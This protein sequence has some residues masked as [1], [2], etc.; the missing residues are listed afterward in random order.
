MNT[1]VVDY[2]RIGLVL[3]GAIAQIVMGGLPDILG[4]EHTISSRSYESQTFVVPAGYAFSIWGVIFLGCLV[5]AIFH[6]L[7][8][9]RTDPAFRQLG[10]LAAIAFWGNSIWEIYVPLMGLDFG[11]L[12]IILLILIA[13]ISAMFIL[14]E[15]NEKGIAFVPIMLMAGWI[16][17]ATF[18]NIS[19]TT[20]LT[21][22]NPFNLSLTSQ[23]IIIILTAG[24]LTTLFAWSFGSIA[25][26]FAVSWGLAAIY[27]IN[28]ARGEMIIAYLALGFAIAGIIFLF[29]KQLNFGTT[30]NSL[31]TSFK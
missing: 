29:A 6:A 26:T 27:V 24:L 9:N 19:T 10:W 21:D 23:A 25:Y 3:F 5:F 7:P 31:I 12:A 14:R 11:S 20:F 13:L 17:V 15:R 2:F 30:I 18:A 8:A 4:W 1:K 22:F 28:A 16:S